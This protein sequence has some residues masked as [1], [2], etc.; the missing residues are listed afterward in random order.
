MYPAPQVNLHLAA[1]QEFL[2]FD[3]NGQNA[4][5]DITLEEGKIRFAPT[6]R[7]QPK[8]PDGMKKIGYIA[9]PAQVKEVA[10]VPMA[11]TDFYGND[12]AGKPVL[13]GPFTD[14][15]GECPW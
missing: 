8:L 4:W 10:A 13:P 15:S 3:M 9:D 1:W 2:G 5:F 11:N 12:R 6:S 7:R 14:I